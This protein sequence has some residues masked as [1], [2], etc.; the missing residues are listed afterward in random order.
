ME[1]QVEQRHALKARRGCWFDVA[2][3]DDQEA[4]WF[5]VLFLLGLM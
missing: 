2:I 3:I 4:G 1:T 5:L